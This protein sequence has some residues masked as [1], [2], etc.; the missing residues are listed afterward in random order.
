MKKTISLLAV[1]TLICNYAFSQTP[2]LQEVTSQ[3]NITSKPIILNSTFNSNPNNTGG[4]AIYNSI[5]FLS[6]FNI[7]IASIQSFVSNGHFQDRGGLKFYTNSNGTLTPKLTIEDGTG[8]VGLGTT[9]PAYKLDINGSAIAHGELISSIDDLGGGGGRI[10]LVNPGK[11]EA[12]AAST[13]RIFNMGGSYNN[14]LQFWAYD[15][16]GC[17]SGLCENKF[18]ISDNGNVGVGTMN[19][20]YKMDVNGTGRFGIA[21]IGSGIEQGFYQDASNG[22]YR[23]LNNGDNGFYFQDNGG[24]NTSMFIG[25]F[26]P[27]SGRVGI[28]TIRPQSELA[29]KGTIT[30]MKV[31]V[32]QTGWP[33]YVFDSSYQLPSLPQIET[34]IHQNKHLPEVPS[35]TEVKTNGLDLGDN[36]AILLKKIEELTLYIIQQNKQIDQQNKQINQ[37]N[38]QLILQKKQMEQIEGRL[39][40]LETR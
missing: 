34:F 12:G 24:A 26:G 21:K 36:Q 2:T 40:K 27:F 30:S 38:T 10:T 29:V 17:G 9:T 25:L 31:K 3:G 22:A 5:D 32:T 11:T 33:D 35:A 39:Q 4:D 37:Q 14:S 13:W 23:S 15:N 8:N 16:A 20:A 18:T 7:P 28:G 1:T 6:G 19:P